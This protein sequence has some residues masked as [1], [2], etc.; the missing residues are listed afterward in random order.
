MCSSDDGTDPFRYNGQVGNTRRNFSF[1]LN[2]EIDDKGTTDSRGYK[3][4]IRQTQGRN[5]AEKIMIWEELAP[6]DGYCTRPF[7]STDDFPS[8]RHGNQ[9][10]V[11]SGSFVQDAEGTGNYCFFDGHVESL[12]VTEILDNTNDRARYKYYD[13]GR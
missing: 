1:S 5:A 10:R 6:N 4:G 3:W 2:G 8:G 7:G 9:R 12:P 13:I 11:V